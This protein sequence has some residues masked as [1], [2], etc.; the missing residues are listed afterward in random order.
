MVVYEHGC[1]L[2]HVGTASV[3]EFL[4]PSKAPKWAIDVDVQTENANRETTSTPAS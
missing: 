2:F 4:G 1:M 3:S